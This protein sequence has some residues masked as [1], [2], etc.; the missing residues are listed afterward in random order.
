MTGECGFL[1][2]KT[3]KENQQKFQKKN[4]I[5]ILKEYTP[6]LVIWFQEMLLVEELKKFVMKEEELDQLVLRSILTFK[7]QLKKKGKIS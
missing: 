6:L 2:R 4:E 1:K 7:K 3:I 5:I